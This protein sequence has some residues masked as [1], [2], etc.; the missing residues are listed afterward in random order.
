M[1]FGGNLPGPFFYFLL[2]PP[3]IFGNDIYNQSIVWHICWLSL[4]YALSSYFTR[5]VI[6]HTESFLIFLILFITAIGPPILA[7]LYFAWNSSFAILF[8]ILIIMLLY[9]WREERKNYYLYFSGL[10]IALGVQVHLLTIIHIITVLLYY[11]FRSEKKVFPL[12]LFLLIS[13]SPFLLYKVLS[14]FHVFEATIFNRRISLLN[15][16]FQQ[17]F[18][19][20]WYKDVTFIFNFSILE[21][22]CFIFFLAFYKFL[23][24]K[25]WPF[26]KS[27]GNLF[28]ITIIPCFISF[29]ASV[30]GHWYIYFIPIFLIIFFSKCFD[31]LMPDCLDK[32]QF[33]LLFY[34]MF[35]ICVFI[36]AQL[37][38]IIYVLNDFIY[39]KRTFTTILLSTA[40]ISFLII[41]IKINSKFP[42]KVIILF[43]FLFFISYI[44]ITGLKT[45]SEQHPFSSTDSPSYQN[46]SSLFQRIFLQT[47][48][49]AKKAMNRLYVIGI[50]PEVSLLF[51]YSM[52]VENIKKLQ[53][54][55]KKDLQQISNGYIVT[56]NLEN[57]TSYSKKNWKHHFLSNPDLYLDILRKEIKEKKILLGEPELHGKYWLIPYKTTKESIFIEG[58]SNVGQPYYW[59]QPGWLRNCNLTQS[60]KDSDEFYYCIVFPGN[61]QKA[62]V[63]IKFHKN[64]SKNTLLDQY[65]DISFWGPLLGTSSEIDNIDGFSLWS[66]IHIKLQCNE[67]NFIFKSLPDLGYLETKAEPELQRLTTPLKLRIPL[68]R[69]TALSDKSS[70]SK[71]SNPFFCEKK[72]INKIELI[73]NFFKGPFIQSREDLSHPMSQKIKIIWNL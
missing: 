60:F 56:L 25:K 58:F 40:L 52:A 2:F 73:F 12:F 11:I 20:E 1:S 31:D 16:T 17:F 67:T 44:K 15:D 5:R 69:F 14:Y 41:N 50:D 26:K 55:Q 33:Y 23:T 70:F 18:S 7:P 27:T 13:F 39:T 3:L 30:N 63:H 28:I 65:M 49:S 51:K 46:L 21:T 32:K 64:I 38:F 61:L 62:G 9:F 54:N 6:K 48:W 66:N 10:T 68:K 42:L 34:T 24:K 8:H 29:L 57:F 47:N 4:S 37:D 43:L 59:E 71:T 35:L 22:S 36:I 19:L 72:N 45:Y 53:K